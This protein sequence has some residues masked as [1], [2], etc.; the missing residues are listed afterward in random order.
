MQTPSKGGQVLHADE[1]KT[2]L[3][4]PNISGGRSGRWP[5][6]SGLRRCGP[7]QWMQNFGEN[8]KAILWQESSPRNEHART[9][10]SDGHVV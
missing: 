1:P 2:T 6:N 7:V 10:G 8:P 5:W 4:P 3:I 9:K